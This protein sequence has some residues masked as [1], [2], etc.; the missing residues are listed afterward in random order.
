MDARTRA[1][2]DTISYA[3]G[4]WRGG[5]QEGYR[6]MFGGGLADPSKTGGRH[7]DQV[8]HGGR[9]SSA[10]AGRYQFMPA[11]W[12]AASKAAGVRP[13]QFF[14]PAAQDKAAAYLASR[15][16]GGTQL[17]DSLTPE[18]AAKL[19]P[20]WASF[21]TAS[22]S[23]YY[24][25]QSVKKLGELDSFYRQ[26]LAALGSGGG[27]SAPVAAPVMPAAA[28]A[29]SGGFGAGEIDWTRALMGPSEQDGAP[30][31]KRR[32][33]QVGLA[34]PSLLD[35][36]GG[37]RMAGEAAASAGV[38]FADPAQNPFLAAVGGGT[39]RPTTAAPTPSGA[40]PDQVA[41]PFMAAIGKVIESDSSAPTTPVAAPVMPAA[42]RGGAGEVIGEVGIL[43]V[44]KRIQGRG[45]TVGENPHIGSGRVGK[46]SP[47]S[48]HYVGHAGDI[49]FMP[50]D[51]KRMRLP[52]DQWLSR[53]KLLGS[54]LKEAFPDAEIFHPGHDP[55]GGHH[56]HVHLAFKGGRARATEA[57]RKY[58][59]V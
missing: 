37:G 13:D 10:A 15:R 42:T 29:S 48:H 25:N 18:V 24:P 36:V 5:G 39:K 17:G 11:T 26:R 50:E 49:K 56:G 45:I 55:V 9:V 20:E 6:V 41:D 4:T 40:A 33:A 59:F 43:D 58:G 1:L 3:E 32:F 52:D 8:V 21:P 14:D 31:E 28:G 34:T 2:L 7:P 16:L 23:S 27:S 38:D 57:A 51:M 30:T 54:Q 46:H 47:N 19:A 35:S 22:G 12:E 44:L 53:T